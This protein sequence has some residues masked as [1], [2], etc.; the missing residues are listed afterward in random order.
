MPNHTPIH[1]EID[2]GSHTIS[3]SI[4]TIH[5]GTV[6]VMFKGINKDGQHKPYLDSQLRKYV[7][8]G[9]VFHAPCH[10]IAADTAAEIGDTL[11]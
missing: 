9:V 4:H 2:Y 10:S 8:D 3:Y 7:I 5:D 11:S 6:M 1:R